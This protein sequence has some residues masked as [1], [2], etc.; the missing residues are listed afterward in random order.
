MSRQ[1]I[2]LSGKVALITGAGQGIGASVGRL[3][4]DRGASVV[5]VD[6]NAQALESVAAE[7]A[8]DRV[9]T[10]EADVRELDSM[11]AAVRRAGDRFGQVNIAVANAG[12]TPP[13]ATLR[14]VE[15]GAFERVIDINL[16][17]VFN[18]A[19][20]CIED[21]IATRGHIQVVGSCAAFAP[22]MG[23][24]A[25]MIS[26]SGVEQLGRALDIELCAHHASAGIAYFGIVET[27]LTRNTLD[28]DELGRE[29]GA[30][31]PWPL[32]RRIT[33]DD[34]AAA[35]VDAITG[36]RARVIAPRQWTV[37]SALRGLINP[38]L[39]ARLEKDRRVRDIV[40]RLEERARSEKVVS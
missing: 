21:V 29:I 40:L 19:R 28:D 8:S 10:V 4:L 12:V 17:G 9:L 14:T 37:Y 13:P 34:A 32:N 5:L 23:G 38:L 1:P 24:S 15:P 20:A 22:G 16:M 2:A 31:L 27:A 7:L 3:L 25:Y 36:R 33:A 18:T 26:K 11:M 30:Q 35:I 6:V 39:D